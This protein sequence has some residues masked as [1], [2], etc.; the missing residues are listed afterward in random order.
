M[1][2]PQISQINKLKRYVFVY[3]AFALILHY[4]YPSSWLE[5]HLLLGLLF[6]FS[7]S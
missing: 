7:Y 4:L 1:A 3:L 2:E 5:R 6:Y